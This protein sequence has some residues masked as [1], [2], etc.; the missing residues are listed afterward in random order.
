[1][2]R[3]LNEEKD[4][5]FTLIA[6]EK[7]DY[8]LS[9]NNI[10]EIS[11]IKLDVEGFEMSVLKGAEKIIRAT[12]PVLFIELDDDNLRENNTDA[13]SLIQLLTG[14]GYTKIF[15]AVDSLPITTR[16]DFQHAHYDIVAT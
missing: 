14:F 4:Y 1:M 9:T 2:N 8:F 3:I 7:L 10:S 12:K 5:P 16:T 11:L 13:A 15:R 6:I